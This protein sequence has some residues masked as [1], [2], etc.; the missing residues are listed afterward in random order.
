MM[1]EL[2]SNRCHGGYSSWYNLRDLSVMSTWF[3]CGACRGR[4]AGVGRRPLRARTR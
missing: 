2:V 4:G 3:Y 1:G